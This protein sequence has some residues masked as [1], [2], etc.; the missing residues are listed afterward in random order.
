MTRH[1]LVA[2]TAIGLVLSAGSVAAQTTKLSIQNHQ[3]P[4]STS[5]R[6]IA[7]FRRKRNPHVRR[8]H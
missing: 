2:A 7:D 3:A 6:M 5:G 8:R 1:S 4:E